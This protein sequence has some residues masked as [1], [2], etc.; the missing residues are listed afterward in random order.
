M[1]GVS[2]TVSKDKERRCSIQYI[3]GEIETDLIQN[4]IC[5]Q[6]KTFMEAKWS[7]AFTKHEAGAQLQCEREKLRERGSC[8]RLTKER[9]ITN[10]I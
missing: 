4:T 5:P 10:D 2:C 7:E 8:L 3:N 1:F 6:T 9:K